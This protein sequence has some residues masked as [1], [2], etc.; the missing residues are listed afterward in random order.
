MLFNEMYRGDRIVCGKIDYYAA[1]RLLSET[2]YFVIYADCCLTRYVITDARIDIMEMCSWCWR[3]IM[4]PTV[5]QSIA[6]NWLWADCRR[7]R[8]VKSGIFTASESKH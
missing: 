2:R 7:P 6:S 5:Q 8:S 4:G 1:D 3:N